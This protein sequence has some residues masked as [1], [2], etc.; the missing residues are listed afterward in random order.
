MLHGET[1][2]VLL[3]NPDGTPAGGIRAFVIKPL[4]RLAIAETTRKVLS[5]SAVE[6]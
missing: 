4:N 5:K 2:G 3:K 6:L 1:G